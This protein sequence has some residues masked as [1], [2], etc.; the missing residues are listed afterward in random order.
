MSATPTT[1]ARIGCCSNDCGQKKR[2]DQTTIAAYADRSRT[3]AWPG[4]MLMAKE[5]AHPTLQLTEGCRGEPLALF[6]FARRGQVLSPFFCSTAPLPLESGAWRHGETIRSSVYQH[7]GEPQF[8]VVR[9]CVFAATWPSL[10]CN[11]RDP[12]DRMRLRRRLSID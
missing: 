5:D 9:M 10:K 4:S 8:S 11:H 2:D 7:L 6:A 12:F 1:A 3:D